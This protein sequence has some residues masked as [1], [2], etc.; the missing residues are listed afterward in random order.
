MFEN[1][2]KFLHEYGQESI[3]EVRPKEGEPGYKTGNW[4]R[5]FGYEIGENIEGEYL[6]FGWN[7]DYGIYADARLG[8]RFSEALAEKLST[9]PEFEEGLL[10][11]VDKDIEEMMN[12]ELKNNY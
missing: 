1:I 10:E 2:N 6:I 12:L 11:A 7:A 3:E 5:G 8:N 9:S 4:S